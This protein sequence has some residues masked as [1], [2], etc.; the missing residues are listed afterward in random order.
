MERT[1]EFVKNKA[2]FGGYPIQEQVDL[3]ESLGVRYFV[4][5]TCDGEKKITP[6]KTEYTYIRYSI[7][8]RRVPTNWRSFSQFIIK[9]GNII[10][11]LSDGNKLYLHCK[12]GHGRSGVVVAC[13]LCYLYNMAPPEALS[14]TTKY[15]SCRKEMREKWRKMG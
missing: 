11:G 10:K 7:P 8:D 6:Y 1:S 12:G 15:H 13:L 4:D 3:F 5:L 2:L 9:I 14:M